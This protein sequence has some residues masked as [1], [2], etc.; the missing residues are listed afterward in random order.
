MNVPQTIDN[1]TIQQWVNQHFTEEDVKLKMKQQA[2]DEITIALYIK[3]FKKI[4][5][6]ERI[7]LGI[8]LMC[9]GGFVG[10]ISCILAITN[11]FPEGYHLIL[12]GLTSIAI[13]V[14][15]AGLYLIF[16]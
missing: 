2:F 13:L 10:L 1:Q 3:E 8:K 15:F 14:A 9:F 7:S 16:E 5:L 11:P 6:Q 4:K 12:Y